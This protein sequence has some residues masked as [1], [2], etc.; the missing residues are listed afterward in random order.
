MTTFCVFIVASMHD[1]FSEQC[2]SGVYN[3]FLLYILAT[4]LKPI[5]NLGFPSPLVN[6]E[7]LHFEIILFP[8]NQSYFTAL[9]K[10]GTN[11]YSSIVPKIER[12]YGVIHILIFNLYL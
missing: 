9:R 5:I 8:Q 7:Q 12:S 2:V 3:N 6:R 11:L 1:S 4:L 10:F